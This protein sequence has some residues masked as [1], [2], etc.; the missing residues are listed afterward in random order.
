MSTNDNKKR[1]FNA[2][3]VEDDEVA[4][5][6]ST[7]EAHAVLKKDRLETKERIEEMKRRTAAADQ[8]L[9]QHAM[10][11]DDEEDEDQSLAELEAVALAKLARVEELLR[12]ERAKCARIA[13]EEK[14]AQEK[15]LAR[16]FRLLVKN[17]IDSLKSPKDRLVLRIERQLPDS[18]LREFRANRKL[19]DM[20]DLEIECVHPGCN[21]FFQEKH[22]YNKE[23]DR[24]KCYSCHSNFCYQC[25]GPKN[26]S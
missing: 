14:L 18:V 3:D 23:K 20:F 16:E 8:Q 7:I 19:L 2:H 21:K 6:F 15:R 9:K 10:S 24:R 4:A 25:N 11:D 13:A 22:F 12:F 5:S 1:T 26:C 17:K